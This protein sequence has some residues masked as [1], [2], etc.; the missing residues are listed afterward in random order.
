[1]EIIFATYRSRGSMLFKVFVNAKT[2]WT[3][4]QKEN[5]GECVMWVCEIEI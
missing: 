4:K 5:N 1:M 3:V 2:L